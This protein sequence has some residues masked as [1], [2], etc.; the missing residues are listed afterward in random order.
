M[1]LCQFKVFFLHFIKLANKLKV[2]SGNKFEIGLNIT[3]GI[4]L[5]SLNFSTTDIKFPVILLDPSSDIDLVVEGIQLFSKSVAVVRNYEMLP[6]INRMPWAGPRN[7][8]HPI[9]AQGLG[10][11]VQSGIYFKW[12]QLYQAKKQLKEATGLK[13]GSLSRSE[14][15]MIYVKLMS[16]LKQEIVFSEANSVSLESTKYVF[17]IC[18][19]ILFFGLVAFVIEIQTSSSVKKLNYC[20][21]KQSL[22]TRFKNLE[23]IP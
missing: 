13:H 22:K 3:Q 23:Y 9:L 18:A 15:R 21:D 16:Q 8:L 14:Y 6:F 20:N 4:P 10:Q 1:F 17:A 19:I 7:L 12:E 5:K 2:V 11:L